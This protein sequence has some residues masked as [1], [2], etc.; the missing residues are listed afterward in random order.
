MIGYLCFH[1]SSGRAK[2]IRGFLFG[3]QGRNKHGIVRAAVGYID[4]PRLHF[5]LLSSTTFNFYVCFMHV[6]ALPVEARRGR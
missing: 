3:R 2:E 4:L 6:G 1:P 5:Y